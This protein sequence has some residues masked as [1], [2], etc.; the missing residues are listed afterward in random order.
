[1]ITG[2]LGPVLSILASPG[3]CDLSCLCEGDEN[4]VSSVAFSP[5]DCTPATENFGMPTQWAAQQ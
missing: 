5:R 4:G 2:G 1:M 3:M